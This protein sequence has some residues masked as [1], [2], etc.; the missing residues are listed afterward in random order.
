MDRYP[1]NAITLKTLDQ[2]TYDLYSAIS[3]NMLK[4]NHDTSATLRLLS[5]LII[6]L[7]R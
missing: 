1:H 5:C 6:H 7:E 2:F 4:Y 3:V